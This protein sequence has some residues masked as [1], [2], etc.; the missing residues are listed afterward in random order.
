MSH[1]KSVTNLIK[2]LD[3]HDIHHK[4]IDHKD[5]LVIGPETEIIVSVDGRRSVSGSPG[6]YISFYFIGGVM[7]IVIERA[8]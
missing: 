4:R 8:Q 5:T 2:L 3:A 6:D 1:E 7:E